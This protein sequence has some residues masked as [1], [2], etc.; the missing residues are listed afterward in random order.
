MHLAACGLSPRVRGNPLC[1][2]GYRHF[3]RSIPA[4]TGEPSRTL[5]HSTGPTG[6][7]PR[8]RG[9]QGAVVACPVI[10]GSI[11]AC[12]GEPPP[13][14]ELASLSRGLSP[15]VRGNPDIIAADFWLVRSIPACTGEPSPH[16]TWPRSSW[17]YPRVYGGTRPRD[18]S[19]YAFRGLSPRVRGNHRQALVFV[20]PTGSIPACTGE[21]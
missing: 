7:S 21:P 19:R 17:V 13:L 11:P 1:R 18:T 4:C 5:S 10:E 15:R 12:T 16:A 6:L 3:Q 8:V 20:D 14:M 2:H 9:N